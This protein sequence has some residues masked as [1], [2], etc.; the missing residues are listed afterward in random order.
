MNKQPVGI[1]KFGSMPKEV[2][3]YLDL[4]NPNMYTGH[5]FRRTSGTLLVDASADLTV[6]KRHGAWKFNTVAEGYIS[7]SINNK[8]KIQ[9][10][11]SEGIQFSKK[12]THPEKDL[13]S[14]QIIPTTYE[15]V[16]V[17]ENF[18]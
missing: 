2:A 4:P 14:Q 11:I 8:N 1:N 10:Q 15:T 3:T 12:G 6:L 13:T 9:N 17:Q 5:S 16:Y 18:N 7:E